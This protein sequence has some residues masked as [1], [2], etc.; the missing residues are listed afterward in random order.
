M[1]LAVAERMVDAYEDGVWVIDFS[2]IADPDLVLAAVAGAVGVKANPGLTTQ[3]L[4][5]ALRGRRMMLV[6][7]NC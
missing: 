6:L 3:A 7:D 1:A 4:V 2:L 5:A